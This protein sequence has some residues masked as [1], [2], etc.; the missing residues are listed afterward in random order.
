MIPMAKSKCLHH[1]HWYTC[2]RCCQSCWKRNIFCQELISN[3]IGGLCLSSWRFTLFVEYEQT[4]FFQHW[5]YSGFAIRGL[6]KAPPGFNA[7]IKA[8]VKVVKDHHL[9]HHQQ[10]HQ[11]QY[12]QKHQHQVESNHSWLHKINWRNS[13]ALKGLEWND[14]N[15]HALICTK[16]LHQFDL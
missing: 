13:F 8:T 14:Q 12:Q 2:C 5:E 7:Q 11:H 16:S 6:L 4:F 1:L 10:Q 15:S 3:L 9:N